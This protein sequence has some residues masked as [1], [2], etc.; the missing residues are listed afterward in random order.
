VFVIL[1]VGEVLWDVF[2]DGKALGGAPCNFAYHV[3][4]LGQQGLP[5]SRVGQDELG[6]E[7]L[8]ELDSLG[9]RTDLI[10]RDPVH[11]TGTVL[12]KLDAGGVPDFTIVED[13]AWDYVE[14]ADAWIEAARQADAVCFG[15]LAQRSPASRSAIDRVLEAAGDSVL[16]FDVNFRQRFYSAPIVRE[17]LARA[18]VLKLNEVEVDQMR[19]LLG[20]GA[21]EGEFLRRLMD[22]FQIALACVTRGEE[23]C[24]LYSAERTVSRAVPPVSVVDTVGSG[25]AFSAGLAVKYLQGRPL[26]SIAEGANL[27][28]AYVAGCRGATP[29]M[30]AEIIDRFGSL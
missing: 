16:I 24:T 26:E 23:G 2:E 22:E 12:V 11:A 5:L 20:W 29:P 27:L 17:S 15:T 21:A 6:D 13:V 18:T 19:G 3:G 25:D 28:G 30:P 8:R 7:L 14:P 1:G 10:Q 4:A 9:L